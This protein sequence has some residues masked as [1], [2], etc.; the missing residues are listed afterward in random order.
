MHVGHPVLARAFDILSAAVVRINLR[1]PLFH[2]FTHLVQH[3]VPAWDSAPLTG[4]GQSGFRQPPVQTL[5][6][7]LLAFLT[8][9]STCGGLTITKCLEM[10][11]RGKGLGPLP[12]S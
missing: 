11:S 3:S 10:P 1:A 9:G 6:A 8:L 12:C 4:P 7:T 2:V 5:I